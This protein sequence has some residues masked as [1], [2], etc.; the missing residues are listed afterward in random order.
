[1]ST[2]SPPY[3]RRGDT[4]QGDALERR[5]RLL[6]PPLPCEGDVWTYAVVIERGGNGWGTREPEATN[7]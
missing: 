6:L 5:P 1:M 7:R 3:V 4:E 2:S